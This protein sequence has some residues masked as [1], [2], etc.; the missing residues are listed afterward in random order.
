MLKLVVVCIMLCLSIVAVAAGG[1]AVPADP[2]DQ[3]NF[4]VSMFQDHRWWPAFSALAMLLTWVFEKILKGRLPKK[5]LPWVSLGLAA[6]VQFTGMQ[7]LIAT[8]MTGLA[9]SGLWSAGGKYLPG[10][11]PKK[12]NSQ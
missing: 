3:V 6:A 1:A 11:K 7:A 4:I 12:E 5:A 2:A 8:F 9:G 10:L